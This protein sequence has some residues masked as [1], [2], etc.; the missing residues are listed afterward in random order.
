MRKHLFLNLGIAALSG[1]FNGP[2]LLLYEG[3]KRLS[4]KAR[5]HLKKW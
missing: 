5:Y 4:Q 2:F 1:V 3:S